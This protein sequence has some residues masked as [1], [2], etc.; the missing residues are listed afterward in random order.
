MFRNIRDGYPGQSSRPNPAVLLRHPEENVLSVAEPVTLLDRVT[1]AIGKV[2]S[3][4]LTQQHEDGYWWYELESNVTM[5]SEYL[6]LLHFLGLNDEERDRKIAHHILKHQ[7]ADGTWSLYGGGKGDLST[8]IEAYFAL[9]IAGFSPDDEPLKKARAFILNEGGV[10]ASRVFTKIFLALFGEFDWKAVPSIPVQMNLFPPWFPFNIYNFSSWARATIVPLSV[11]AEYKPV[12]QLN[13]FAGIRELYKEPHKKPPLTP[14]KLPPF[15][16]KRCFLIQDRILKTAEALHIRPM[17]EKALKRAEQWILEHQEPCGDW[18]GIQPPMINSI[19]AL[20]T[21]GYDA[22]SEP[23][24]NGLEAIERFCIENEHEL[25]LQAC[26]SPVWDTALTGLALLYSGKERTHPSLIRASRWLASKQIFTKG[27]WSV[28]RPS[29]NPGGWAFEFENSWYP[30][31]DDTAVVLLLLN[32]YADRDFIQEENMERGLQWVLGMQGK[33]GGW[34]AFDV[35]NDMKLLNQLPFGDLEAMIDPSTPDL[36]G[37]VLELLGLLGYEYM[38]DTV[39]RA[40][41]FLKRTQEKD[42]SWWGRWGVNYLYGTWSVLMGL[43]AIKEDMSSP[44]VRKAVM[45]LKNNQN[46]DGGW[47]EGC[48]SY[49]DP[50]FR[51]RGKSTPSQTAWAILALIAACE[52]TCEEVK[53]GIVYLLER[54]KPEGTWDESEF[55]GTGFPRHF[56]LRY[57]NYRNCFPLMALGQFCAR[58]QNKGSRP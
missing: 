49:E 47:G 58:L 55:T 34:G 1:A 17:R 33:D 9:R 40:I 23:I 2:H 10:E 21:M 36:T 15:S 7:R 44:Y 45:C 35:D 54:Q 31:V 19:I 51:C 4:Y 57:H 43:C 3:Y 18:G 28:K 41:A 29:L 22:S 56:Y 32:R 24:Q 46:A 11:I 16:W 30:D 26:I 8:S 14:K 38:N 25:S 6:M 42:G 52:D 53:R 37:R 13:D 48:E 27:D 50:K 5:T 20:T 12:R 39:Q